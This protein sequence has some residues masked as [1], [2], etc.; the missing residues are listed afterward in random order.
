MWRPF[1]PLRKKGF[2]SNAAFANGGA[3]F[4]DSEV[5]Q[6]CRRF[7]RNNQRFTFYR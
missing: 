2:A 7:L 3:H 1:E 5:V 6:K 4:D